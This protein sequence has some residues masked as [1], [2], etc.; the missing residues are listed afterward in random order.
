MQFE[1]KGARLLE[2]QT[3]SQHFSVIRNRSK[4][5]NMLSWKK[6][7]REERSLQAK[8]KT[9][10]QCTKYLRDTMQNVIKKADTNTTWNW[11]P[12]CKAMRIL[13]EVKKIASNRLPFV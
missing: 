12:K 5:C 6:A 7:Q 3:Q 2:N 10:I 4:W 8:K 11:R 9:L 13:G 1:M